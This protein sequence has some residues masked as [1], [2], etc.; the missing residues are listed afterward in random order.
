MVLAAL[1]V[2]SVKYFTVLWVR[3]GANATDCCCIQQRT[4]AGQWIGPEL[5]W[6]TLG[7]VL[8]TLYT[9]TVHRGLNWLL[10]SGNGGNYFASY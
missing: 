1:V 9:W 5:G 2:S 3:F 10:A 6:L 7:V 4:R 8:W